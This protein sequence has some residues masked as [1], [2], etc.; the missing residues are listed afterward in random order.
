MMLHQVE[1]LIN[2]RVFWVELTCPAPSQFGHCFLES[3]SPVAPVPWHTEQVTIQ[4]SARSYD[5]LGIKF[6][7][8][9]STLHLY[10]INCALIFSSVF[11][12]HEFFS[13]DVP[14]LCHDERSPWL[15]YANPVRYSCSVTYPLN[16]RLYPLQNKTCCPNRFR[17]IRF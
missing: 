14:S 9:M 16:C 11:F 7:F 6:T 17:N 13:S 5:L 3:P 4:S 10:N 8:F 1:F 15:F 12:L 2:F